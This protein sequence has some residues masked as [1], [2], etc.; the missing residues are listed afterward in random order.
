MQ[1]LSCS[2]GKQI[3]HEL[4]PHFF[5]FKEVMPL[6]AAMSH[7]FFDQLSQQFVGDFVA[8]L[9]LNH[10]SINDKHFHKLSSS[11][12]V[13]GVPNVNYFSF[14]CNLSVI[15]VNKSLTGQLHPDRQI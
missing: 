5:Y 2:P 10:E 12:V 4:S 14:S 1:T 6:T 15:Q 3:V 13:A 7:K 8:M 11:S 9:Q